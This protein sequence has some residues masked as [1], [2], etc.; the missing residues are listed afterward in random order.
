[1]QLS[2]N[3]KLFVD[4]FAACSLARLSP[5]ENDVATHAPR[6]AFTPRPHRVDTGC[7]AAARGGPRR[8][9]AAVAIQ[10]RVVCSSHSLTM[11]IGRTEAHT[12]W[13]HVRRSRSD[14]GEEWCDGQ[15]SKWAAGRKKFP[16]YG[17]NG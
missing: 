14:G 4:R 11:N 12:T 13:A 8:Q 17:P 2:H 1:M 7:I 5:E 10:S 3:H 15:E 6:G 16:H 9:E